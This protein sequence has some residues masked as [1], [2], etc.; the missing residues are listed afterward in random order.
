MTVNLPDDLATEEVK[1]LILTRAE[2]QLVV[3]AE[4]EIAQD[5]RF[6]HL[7]THEIHREVRRFFCAAAV[8]KSTDHVTG[9]TSRLG[10]EPLGL[11][12]YFPLLY[13]TVPAPYELAGVLFLPLGHESIP[14]G[15]FLD[16]APPCG[17]VVSV[18]TRGTNYRLMME[19]GRD[20]VHHVLRILR[21][22]LREHRLLHDWQLRFHL[23]KS[24]AFDKDYSGW[25][26]PEDTAFENALTDEMREVIEG[27]PLSKLPYEPQNDVEKK[28]N[29]ALKWMDRARLATE[30]LVSTLY[31]FFALEGLLGDRSE[32]LKAH[33]LVFRRMVL[34]HAV[35]GRF[36][37]PLQ[38]YYLYDEVRSYAVHGSEPPDVSSDERSS[39]DW[40]VRLALNE[41][42]TFSRRLQLKKQ[43]QVVAALHGHKD[44]AEVLEWLRERD[45]RWEDF[46]P[47]AQETRLSPFIARPRPMLPGPP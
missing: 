19:R 33:G 47:L 13:L 21:V 11:R 34:G 42:L 17:G 7:R 28:A 40:D 14:A 3:Q 26:A 23:G 22:G 15:D 1:S 10:R 29:L 32:R 4:R 44:A 45:R 5:L 16:I 46:N 27:Q 41:Y 25:Q 31:L 38:L 8:D 9:F 20:Q 12:C 6:E 18:P 37:N 2:A 36:S 43:S 24:Y 35:S 30:P 39:F